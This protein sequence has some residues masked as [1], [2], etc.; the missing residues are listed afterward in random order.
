MNN[1]DI[2]L[3]VDDL[4]E[5]SL[6]TESLPEAASANTAGSFGTASCFGGCAATVGC[7]GSATG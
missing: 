7:I 5:Q 3:F 1:L 2:D 4:P 6:S